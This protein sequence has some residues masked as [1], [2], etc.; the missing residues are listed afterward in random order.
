MGI[1]SGTTAEIT[2]GT[3]T[4]DKEWTPK[5]LHDYIA[6]VVGSVN[7]MRFKGTL[8]TGGDVSTLPTTGVK[9]GD[10]YMVIT[11][12][13]YAGQTCE[14]GDLVIATATTPTWT[15]AQTNID[16]A[17]TSITG[18]SP[19]NVTGSG[20]SRNIAI[21]DATS[22]SSGLMSASDKSNLDDLVN[23]ALYQGTQT[24][25]AGTTSKTYSLGA[26]NHVGGYVAKNATTGEQVAI[27]FLE[28]S[29]TATWSIAS[30]VNYDIRIDF[31][32]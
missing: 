26:G 6:T 13:T 24:L 7:A 32:F 16:G 2:A 4:S 27:D 14:V 17:I 15:V 25:T 12:G 28:T 10:T 23:D 18:T 8:G 5:I 21:P 1:S 3:D 11:A 29:N 30:A 9:V 22:G 31:A 19:V 20:A